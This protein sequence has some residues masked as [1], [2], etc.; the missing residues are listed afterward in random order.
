M[1][2]T[3]QT[4]PFELFALRY[5]RHGGRTSADNYIGGDLHEAG[6]DL[7]YYVWVARR[8]DRLFVIDTGFGEQAAQERGR[9]LALRPAA[10]LKLLGIDAARVDEVILTHLHYDHA[11]TLGDFPRACFH[12][13]PKEAAYA[14][15]PCMCHGFLRAP[16]DV[17]DVVAFIRLNFAGRIAFHDEVTELA[18]GLTLHRTGGHSAGLQVVRVLTRRGWVVIASDA[19]HLYR[20]YRN[21]LVFPAVYHAGELLEGYGMLRRLADSDDHI[22]PGHDPMVMSLYPAPSA[23]LEGIAA[24]LD[25]AP[26]ES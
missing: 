1:D 4:E 14:T 11:G 2:I 25:V 6:E 20:N 13:Q 9:D 10:A 5:A 3:R 23:E 16:F 15:G 22:I 21:G 12:L 18:D 24:R 19:T 7:F 26:R 17:E 8:S